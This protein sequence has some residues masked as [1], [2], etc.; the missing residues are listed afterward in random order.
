MASLT[1]FAVLVA[2]YGAYCMDTLAA[3]RPC[4]GCGRT[5]AWQG[6]RARWVL[7]A[8]G[9]RDR[10]ALRRLR[11]RRCHTV[12]TVFPPW[13]VPYE[14]LLLDGLATLV[15]AAGQGVS[16]TTVATTVGVDGLTVRRRWRRWG[17]GGA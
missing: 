8:P 14:E 15:I 9:R 17:P 3:W 16:W 5:R 2:A 1:D 4:R 13:I 11:C 10:L 12:E 7:W 6:T